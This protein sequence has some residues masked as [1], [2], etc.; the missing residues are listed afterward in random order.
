[1]E[2][3][4]GRVNF[5]NHLGKQI[6]HIDLSNLTY[7]QMVIAVEEAKQVIAGQPL[8][9]LRTL[10]DISNSEFTSKVTAAMKQ[11]TAHNKPYVKAA[12]I[13]GAT[14]LRKALVFVVASF[15]G[16]DLAPFDDVA[17]AKD[18]LAKF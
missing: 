17:S 16:R 14:G 7:D 11:Y 6:L 15:S 12:A 18:W 3:A 4:M 13:V 1:M 2:V 8:N 5:V 9:S 10:T